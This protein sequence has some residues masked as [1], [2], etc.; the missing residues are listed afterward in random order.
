MTSVMCFIPD[1]DGGGAQRTMVN[2][3]NGF[4]EGWLDA[5][6][7]VARGNGPAREW[8][9]DRV[10]F[11]NLD[12]GRVLRSIVPLRDLLRK[13]QPDLL[14]TTML[15]ANIA[16]VLAC[17]GLAG[18][19]DIVCRETNSHRARGDLGFLRR[20]LA[21][22]AY[23][24]AD[25][26]V[27]LSAGVNRELVEDY[28]LD[29]NRVLTIHNPV[30]LHAIRSTIQGACSR[31]AP[32][33]DW[34]GQSPVVVGVGRLTHQKGFDLLLQAVANLEELNVRA[35]ILGEGPLRAELE[36]QVAKLG[37]EGRVLLPGF[38]PDAAAWMTHADVFALSS[39]WEGFGH[40]IV[41]AMACGLPVVSMDCPYG[42]ADIIEAG[43]N[44]LLLPNGDVRAFGD[45]IRRVLTDQSVASGLREQGAIRA[46]D[47]E[48]RLIRRRYETLF[49]QAGDAP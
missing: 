6:L 34:A 4:A 46:Q 22:W 12:R 25:R 27:A 32:W 33:G 1:L 31:P 24:R 47:F 35:V 16:G 44:G 30:D 9:S 17:L 48:T 41:E 42:P 37:L 38:V 36:E 13:E 21:G 26:I 49:S 7:V 3:L 15:D 29:P 14:F 45:A 18:K 5:Q 20:K 11:H 23:R 19:P 28:S 2:L 43:R 10:R 40:V 39:R 8:L